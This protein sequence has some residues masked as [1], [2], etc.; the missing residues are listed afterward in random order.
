MRIN[1]FVALATGMSR[2]AADKAIQEGSVVVN[3]SQA[4]LGQDVTEA[5]KIT[6]NNK[7]IKLPTV[8]TT[9]I[10]NKPVDY[11][12]SRQGQGSKTIYNLLPT[13]LHNLKPVGRLDKNSS[14]LLLMTDDGNLSNRLTHPKYS[15]EKIY[16]VEL[17][18]PLTNSDATRIQNGVE[19]EDGLSK[20][21]LKGQGTDWTVT[22]SEGRNRQIR[23]TF[24]ALGYTVTNLHRT[25]FGPYK[26][27]NLMLG[28]Y[29]L[30]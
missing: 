24:A 20:L 25:H 8:T 27:E 12:C 13:E 30:L 22:M 2:R 18:H 14:G 28:K 11:V 6:I 17:S 19:L 16:E 5:D 10:L 7:Q 21:Q 4:T 9:L 23:R 26:L 29:Q 3:G 1:Q 15:K